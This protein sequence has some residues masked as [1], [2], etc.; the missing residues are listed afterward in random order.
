MLL[1]CQET[2][3][4]L[5]VCVR[6]CVI[7]IVYDYGNKKHV[8][9]VVTAR[10]SAY[11]FETDSDN[12]MLDWIRAIKECSPADDKEVHIFNPGFNSH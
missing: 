12:V 5:T 9:R 8:F 4:I 6:P 7:N 3:N 10:R 11:L 1:C 2:G